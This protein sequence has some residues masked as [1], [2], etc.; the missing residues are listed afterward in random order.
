MSVPSK[1]AKLGPSTEATTSK[2]LERAQSLLA[3]CLILLDNIDGPYFYEAIGSSIIPGSLS[4]LLCITDTQ[5]MAIYQSCGFYSVK[6]DY[7][8]DSIF[9]AFIEAFDIP[10]GITRY[11]DPKTRIRS[12][13]IKIGQ[14][15]YPVKP[16]QQKKDQLQP[17]SG[18]SAK[19]RG[20]DKG[21]P[22]HPN[23]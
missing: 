21:T 8:I 10:I 16:L 2:L 1:N 11:R 22:R 4:N 19:G 9:Q 12:L 13:L 15:A 6:R 18:S 17:P 5:L 14:G 7:F 3:R 20:C 23:K